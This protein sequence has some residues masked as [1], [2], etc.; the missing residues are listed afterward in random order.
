M[1][2]PVLVLA[3]SGGPIARHI[4]EHARDRYDVVALTRSV[5]GT[6]PAGT[7]AVSWHPSAASE[8]DEAAL[9]ALAATLQGAVA[10]VNLA[11]ASIG[12]GRM[13]AEHRRRVRQSRLQSTETLVTAVARCAE[14][15]QVFVQASASGY[16]GDRG[17]ERLDEDAG[18][19][20]EGPLT[21][22]AKDWEEASEPVEM[23]TR[24]VVTRFGL[25]L[26]K[27]APA[28]QRLLTPIR[29]LDA[30]RL[31]SGDQWWPW[32]DADDLA[33]AILFLIEQPEARGAFNVCAPHPVRQKEFSRRVAARIGRT[34][35]VPAPAFAL[36]LVLGR[37]AD[38]LLLAS[39]RMVPGRLQEL[40]FSW[41]SPELDDLLDKLTGA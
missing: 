38:L 21:V 6:E 2:N 23:H 11:G 16:Y 3:G 40:G 39:Q 37:T 25:V 1:S 18:P 10:V 36:R 30:G 13:D 20:D 35:L 9:D 19:G 17:D 33:R 28:W 34:A 29:W 12:D 4:T 32:V 5:D 14:P 22:V 15:P 24:R 41:E 27:D 8:H 7:R 31:G 26:A